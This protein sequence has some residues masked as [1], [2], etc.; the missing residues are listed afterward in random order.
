VLAGASSVPAGLV[1][2]L[3]EEFNREIERGDT[4]PMEAPLTLEAFRNYWFGAFAA[5]MLLGNEAT[6]REGRNW[7]N[8]CLGAFYT[9]PNYPGV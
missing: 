2:F 7:A 6:L 4:Y 3:H 9:K 8:E 5:V 1:G